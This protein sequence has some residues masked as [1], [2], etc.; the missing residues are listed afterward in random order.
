MKIKEIY[1][2]PK[3]ELFS[4]L[5]VGNIAQISLVDPNPDDDPEMPDVEVD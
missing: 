4:L 3:M 1:E 5:T 2:S